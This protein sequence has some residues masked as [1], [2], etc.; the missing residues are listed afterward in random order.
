M[1]L[2]FR[3]FVVWSRFIARVHSCQWSF[4]RLLW[5]ESPLFFLRG[6]PRKA[7]WILSA[8]SSVAGSFRSMSISSWGGCLTPVGEPL[9]ASACFGL[10]SHS[11]IILVMSQ[12]A[13]AGFNQGN[14]L[15]STHIYNLQYLAR[16]ID[17]QR[18]H[19]SSWYK[20]KTR[21]INIATHTE[22]GP[23]YPERVKLRALPVNPIMRK[24]ASRG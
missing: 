8:A 23:H 21:S 12:L 10:S 5:T 3:T 1:K 9:S 24:S 11:S 7:A 4:P 6:F 18:D 13:K 2:G 14:L 22:N 16:Q 15:Y 17:R 20:K 19:S